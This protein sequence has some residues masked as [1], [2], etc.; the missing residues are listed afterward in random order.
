[1]QSQDNKW[2]P[3]APRIK[4]HKIQSVFQRDPDNRCK[5]FLEGEWTRPAFGYLAE[6]DWVATE[7]VD[8]TN[9]RI[10]VLD[11]GYRIGGRTDNAQLHPELMGVLNAIGSRACSRGLEGLTLFG[12][13][14]GAGIQK[15]GESYGEFKSFILFD[16]LVTDNGM[17]LER[18]DVIDIAHQLEVPAVPVVWGGTLLDAVKIFDGTTVSKVWNGTAYVLG[19]G[20]LCSSLRIKRTVERP[21]VVDM[22]VGSRMSGSSTLDVS[23]TTM[24]VVEVPN[25]VEGWVLR[26]SIELKTRAG[27]RIITKIKV[28]DYPNVQH[29]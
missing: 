14:C 24:K 13:G 28:S 25:L 27:D 1:M 6:T 12:E 5:T 8:G 20:R 4:Y 9:C 15:G 19:G 3:G 7:K 26:P 11:V 17:F 21:V 10:E 22:S 23:A 29:V 18:A 2:I 16:V